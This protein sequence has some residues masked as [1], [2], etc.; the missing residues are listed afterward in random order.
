VADFVAKVGRN[1]FGLL[2]SLSVEGRALTRCPDASYA[3]STLRNA[4]N[5]S[6]W[7]SRDQRC[8]LSQVL[9]DGGKNKLIL[10]ASRAA[11]SK[12]TEPQDALQVGE[13]HLDLLS[14]MPRPLE[15]LGASE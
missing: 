15:A 5:L 11:Q 4:Q 8:E 3:T 9:G 14:L 7:R 2:L 12:S 6:G 13:P 10:G 1:G